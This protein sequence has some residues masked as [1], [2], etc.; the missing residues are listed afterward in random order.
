VL[1]EEKI[2][3]YLIL[4]I[5]MRSSMNK[6]RF[7]INIILLYFCLISLLFIFLACGDEGETTVSSDSTTEDGGNGQ[8]PGDTDGVQPPA[9]GEEP[10]AG[11]EISFA[12]DIK[13]IFDASCN[14]QG[15]HGANPPS[16]LL[17][18]SYDNLKK[19]GR[20][21]PAFIAKNAKDSLIVKR[22]EPGGGMPPGGQLADE[23]V[24]KIKKWIDEGGE[25]N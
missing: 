18:T 20:S 9:N 17:L 24:D 10:P 15:C 8:I 22:I 11:P 23:Q 25:N 19:G 7:P 4:E 12:K 16:Q 3:L 21:G 14:F 13:P 6:K 5:T 2:E 1:F